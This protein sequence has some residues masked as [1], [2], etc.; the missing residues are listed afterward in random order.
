[1][2][3]GVNAHHGVA[4]TAGGEQRRTARTA[5]RRRRAV[6]RDG[7]T[8]RKAREENSKINSKRGGEDNGVEETACHS[9]IERHNV[10]QD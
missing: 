9:Y 2:N 5:W 7:N 8:L 4:A 10:L 3:G 1:M 6:D